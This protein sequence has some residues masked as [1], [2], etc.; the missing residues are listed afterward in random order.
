MTHS[1]TYQV[2]QYL[3]FRTAPMIQAANYLELDLGSLLRR[4]AEAGTNATPL[5]GTVSSLES[6]ESPRFSHL[7]P[8]TGS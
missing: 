7:V 6:L 5:C 3:H 1:D 8:G 4:E 2:Q